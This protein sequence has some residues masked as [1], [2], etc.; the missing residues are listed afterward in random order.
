M[1]TEDTIGDRCETCSGT[2]QQVEMKPIKF[3]HKIARP[4]VCKACDGTGQ[5]PKVR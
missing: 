2:G 4:P 1:V 3:G 5:K